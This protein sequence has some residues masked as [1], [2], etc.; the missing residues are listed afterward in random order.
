M[1][2]NTGILSPIS[3]TAAVL[4]VIRSGE[5]FKLQRS[6]LDEN[7]K[8]CS[9]NGTSSDLSDIVKSVL[10]HVYNFDENIQSPGMSTLY[11]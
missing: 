7:E 8:E 4:S 2:L 1:S 6:L 10:H 11:S 5:S 3:G 9:D